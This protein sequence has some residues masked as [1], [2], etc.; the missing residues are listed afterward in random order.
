M[1]ATRSLGFIANEIS[2]TYL[3]TAISDVADL[4][5]GE[6][7]DSF[8][9]PRENCA[10]LGEMRRER[11]EREKCAQIHAGYISQVPRRFDKYTFPRGQKE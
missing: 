11:A 2:A 4:Q 8:S 3:S 6:A 10:H 5:R 9:S 1:R 7:R